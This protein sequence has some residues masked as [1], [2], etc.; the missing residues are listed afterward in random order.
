LFEEG[1]IRKFL[2]GLTK[3]GPEVIPQGIQEWRGVKGFGA[4]VKDGESMWT[5]KFKDGLGRDITLTDI[6]SI[7]FEE[8]P[9]EPIPLIESIHI[10]RSTHEAWVTHF[11]PIHGNAVTLVANFKGTA[12]LRKEIISLFVFL[13]S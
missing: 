7:S 2:R 11:P 10:S 13:E 5:V 1:P 8:F 6:M 9:R 4:V 12:R 3:R